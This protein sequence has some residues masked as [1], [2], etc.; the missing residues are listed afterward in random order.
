MSLF[1]YVFITNICDMLN[2]KK[3]KIR[4]MQREID[5]VEEIIVTLIQCARGRERVVVEDP[6]RSLYAG[7]LY[8]HGGAERG[9]D[10]AAG[11]P[12]LDSGGNQAQQGI[13]HARVRVGIGR[14]IR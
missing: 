12:A 4:K 1:I 9:I 13:E 11:I 5:G 7:A 6:G 8:R 2:S 10:F 3:E 14:R